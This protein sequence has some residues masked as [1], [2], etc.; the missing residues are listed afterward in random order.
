MYKIRH[1]EKIVKYKSRDQ[2]FIYYYRLTTNSSENVPTSLSVISYITTGWNK[3]T[4]RN[5][6]TSLSFKQKANL[7]K[8]FF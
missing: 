7:Y 6:I 8:I 4:V 1:P 5:V 2:K 3:P